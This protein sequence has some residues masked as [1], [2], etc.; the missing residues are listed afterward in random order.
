MIKRILLVD[1]VEFNIEF[2][3]TVIKAL[4]EESET[5]IEVDVAY[6]V[7]GAIEKI[8]NNP[9]YHLMVIDMNLPDGSGAD[10]AIEARKKSTQ[11]RL[12]A[13]TI[14]PSKYIED[15][16]FFN[17]FLKKPIMPSDYRYNLREQ[18]GL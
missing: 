16:M 12:V 18:L 1:D 3:R 9:E 11:T 10:I 7:Q 2:E 5:M 8:H 6:T 17:L 4:I 14:Y 13:L 15:E